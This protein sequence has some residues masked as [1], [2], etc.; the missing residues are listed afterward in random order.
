MQKPM[1]YACNVEAELPLVDER[2]NQ[3]TKIYQQLE[4]FWEKKKYATERID[5]KKPICF[6]REE[7]EYMLNGDSIVMYTDASCT[8]NGEDD[9]KA[10]IAV[11]F[12]ERSMYNLSVKILDSAEYL[13][14]TKLTNNKA[15]II[16][17]IKVLEI[18]DYYKMTNIEIRTDSSLVVSY[19]ES[20]RSL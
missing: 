19:F 12:T 20:Y 8:G 4:E 3:V 13:F 1:N 10:G 9:V 11:F 6:T 15:E 5:H 7:R 14:T 2:L 17:I 18:A 16:A